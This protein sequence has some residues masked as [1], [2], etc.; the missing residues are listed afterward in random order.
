MRLFR[1]FEMRIAFNR[2]AAFQT[3]TFE[4]QF[5]LSD[6]E[7]LPVTSLKPTSSFF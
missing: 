4:V 6:P 3:G 7:T 5:E 1:T 2:L